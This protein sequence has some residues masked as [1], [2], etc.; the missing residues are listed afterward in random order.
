MSPSQP[1][2]P[3]SVSHRL[4]WNSRLIRFRAHLQTHVSTI[5]DVHPQVFQGTTH[6]SRAIPPVICLTH[7]RKILIG[8]RHAHIHRLSPLHTQSSRG[9]PEI[10]SRR[11][12]N[13]PLLQTIRAPNR[14]FSLISTPYQLASATLDSKHTPSNN[15]FHVSD[16]PVMSGAGSS[17]KS[18]LVPGVF[19]SSFE[20]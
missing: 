15:A 13:S 3:Q 9:V 14:R 10:L 12:R 16:A 7:F 5:P 4:P 1:P 2:P 19:H 11:L 20:W 17:G 8:Q 6:N 18:R